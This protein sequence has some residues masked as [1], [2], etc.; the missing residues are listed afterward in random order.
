MNFRNDPDVISVT[1]TIINKVSEIFGNRF[2]VQV[3]MGFMTLLVV[4]AF[5]VSFFAR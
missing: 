4:A 2:G 3:V 5:F 1:L